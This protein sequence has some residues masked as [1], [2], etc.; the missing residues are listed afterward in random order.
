MLWVPRS[1]DPLRPHPASPGH[2]AAPLRRPRPPSLI[3]LLAAAGL[4]SGSLIVSAPVGRLG[5][6]IASHTY[7]GSG[8]ARLHNPSL[9]QTRFRP[10]LRS[11]LNLRCSTPSLGGPITRCDPP[12]RRVSDGNSE[13]SCGLH[14]GARARGTRDGRLGAARNS[15]VLTQLLRIA[16]HV[17]SQRPLASLGKHLRNTPAQ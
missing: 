2:H 13:H 1:R 8:R 6:R 3:R 9:E 16:I 5:A 14:P 4:G 17:V 11:A 15:S 12:F 7:E 10:S